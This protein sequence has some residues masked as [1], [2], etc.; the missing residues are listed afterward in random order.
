MDEGL[1][2]LKVEQLIKMFTNDIYYS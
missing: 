2:Y 1:Q